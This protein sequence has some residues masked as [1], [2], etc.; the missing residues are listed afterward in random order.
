MSRDTVESAFLPAHV[1]VLRQHLGRN[2]RQPGGEQEGLVLVEVA[3]VEDQKELGA[4]FWDGFCLDRV[5]YAWREVPMDEVSVRM[6]E[7][8]PDAPE[9][10]FIHIAEVDVPFGG[11]DADPKRAL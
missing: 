2:V 8:V 7:G 5:R 1:E 6:D 4:V 9:I 10:P 11:Y 3:I